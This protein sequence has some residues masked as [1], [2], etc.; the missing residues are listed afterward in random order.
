MRREDKYNP[1]QR[2]QPPPSRSTSVIYESAGPSL[3]G[4]RVSSPKFG[5]SFT[6]LDIP[7]FEL[8]E[9]V[10][11]DFELECQQYDEEVQN[12]SSETFYSSFFNQYK[13]DDRGDAKKRST[14]PLKQVGMTECSTEGLPES[15]TQKNDSVF[16]S[17][18]SVHDFMFETSHSTRGGFLGAPSVR[19]MKIVAPSTAKFTSPAKYVA[20]FAVNAPAPTDFE[21][22]RARV[23]SFFTANNDSSETSVGRLF[24]DRNPQK[25]TAPAAGSANANFAGFASRFELADNSQLQMFGTKSGGWSAMDPHLEGEL[26][27]RVKV[28]KA[29]ALDDTIN[30]RYTL[31]DNQ[32]T[33]SNDV[34]GRWNTKGTLTPIAMAGIPQ[35]GA[36]KPARE[37][38]IR[39]DEAIS[40]RYLYVRFVGDDGVDI[41]SFVVR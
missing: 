10:V 11:D 16:S 4:S 35:K 3:A 41:E 19:E 27:S 7:H 25:P 31:G 36:G 1:K 15:V 20:V 39:F 5:P 2:K 33:I 32:A 30:A 23:E 29:S 34:N 40:A 24:Q 8:D 6:H 17:L 38:T 9:D 14:L 37:L 22:T 18:E 13:P 28:Q 21:S 12:L 26:V